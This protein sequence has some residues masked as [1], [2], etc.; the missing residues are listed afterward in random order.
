M[1]TV[2]S[3]AFEADLLALTP[4]NIDLVNRLFQTPESR[5]VTAWSWKAFLRIQ[6]NA[7]MFD[8][9]QRHLAGS[10]FTTLLW[11]VSLQ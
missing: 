9:A 5:D 6:Q 7:V 4:Y 3:S 1:K 8:L 10:P 11:L 2:F